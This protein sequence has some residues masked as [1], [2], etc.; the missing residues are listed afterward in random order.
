MRRP[1][2][3]MS[4]VAVSTAGADGV[5]VV[6]IAGLGRSESAKLPEELGDL[7]A[8]VHEHAPTKTDESDQS[9]KS[10]ESDRSD[11]TESSDESDQSEA[12]ESSDEIAADVT[13]D[14][15]PEQE[16]DAATPVPAAEGAQKK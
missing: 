12:T 13:P 8:L 16:P 3:E 11:A 14:A 10:D 1:S 4:C 7:A 5:T 2:R 6:E 15:D 9:N